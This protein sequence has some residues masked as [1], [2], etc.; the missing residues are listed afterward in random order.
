MKRS[1][2]VC[3][4]YILYP[5]WFYQG[6]GIVSGVLKKRHAFGVPCL[7]EQAL[8]V[9]EYRLHFSFE[10]NTFILQ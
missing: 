2:V 5:S 3:V 7:A 8:I 9:L 10:F 4:G 6:Q 1:T